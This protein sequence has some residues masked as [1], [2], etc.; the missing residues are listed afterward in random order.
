MPAFDNPNYT[1]VPND[2]F[3]IHLAQMGEAELR[4]VLVLI[5]Q[6]LGYHRESVR[7][8]IS[9]IEAMTGLSRS[10]AIDGCD[11]AIEHGYI[12]KENDG[13]VSFWTLCI[14]DSAANA[15][16]KKGKVA[17]QTRQ[18]SRANAPGTTQLVGQTRQT[19]RANAPGTTQLVGQTRQTSRVA[20]PPSIK[21][22]N[23]DGKESALAGAKESDPLTPAQRK[24]YHLPI[25]EE[26]SP[27]VKSYLEAANS[28]QQP[29]TP[30]P[31]IRMEI[32]ATVTDLDKWQAHLKT[33]H[34]H[35]YRFANVA[36][37]LETYRTGLRSNGHGRDANNG[38]IKST[39][40]YTADG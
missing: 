19:S 30:A 8:S 10:S 23:K 13:G 17:R 3:E 34:M 29:Q 25:G 28:A 18:T 33:W 7:F 22:R 12:V 1:Q 4:V 11:Q 31:E 32:D 39:S 40:S 27:A 16:D 9:N 20:L 14:A 26:P 35:G 37:L 2:L 36:D 5:R 6:T 38:L 21:E 15:L 24:H